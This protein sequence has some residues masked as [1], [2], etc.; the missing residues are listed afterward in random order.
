MNREISL[1]L[2]SAVNPVPEPERLSD[3]LGI[4]AAA[5]LH[6]SEQSLFGCKVLIL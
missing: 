1:E 2:L 4:D 5:L 6:L 3:G